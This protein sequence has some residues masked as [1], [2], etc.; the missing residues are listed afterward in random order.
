MEKMRQRIRSLFLLEQERSE[1]LVVYIRLFLMALYTVGGLGVRKEIPAHSL[2][3]ILIG[4]SV[5]TVLSFIVLFLLKKG[6]FTEKLKYY[7]TTA[8]IVI[9][10]AVLWQFGT[11]RTFKSE[12][13]LV[14]FLWIAIAACASL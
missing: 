7:T 3:A 14:L 12:A 11:F 8:D 9:F 2:Q 10:L 1:K 5:G 13:F 6:L 4:A